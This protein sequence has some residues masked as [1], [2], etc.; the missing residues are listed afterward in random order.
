MEC[1]I[2]YEKAAEDD[3]QV[4][5]CTHSLCKNC[6]SKLRQRICPLCRASINIPSKFMPSILE[7]NTYDWN[8]EDIEWERVEIYDSD[9]RI[10]IRNR[11]SR[12]RRRSR[13]ERNREML[14]ASSRIPDVVSDVHIAEI[15]YGISI[16]RDISIPARSVSDKQQQK[17]RNKRS[18]WKYNYSRNTSKYIRNKK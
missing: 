8:I 12:N 6:L 16:F 10:Q 14:E 3:C 9:F 2:C 17:K 4:L 11:R 18:V 1:P 15:M 5:E 7:D 13:L